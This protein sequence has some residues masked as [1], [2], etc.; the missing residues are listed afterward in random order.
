[1]ITFGN[2]KVKI[3]GK[4]VSLSKMRNR[5]GYKNICLPADNTYH[6]NL[7]ITY[8]NNLTSIC[9]YRCPVFTCYHQRN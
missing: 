8:T 4:I 5:A 1:M 2:E 9:R 7:R 3:E 6:V